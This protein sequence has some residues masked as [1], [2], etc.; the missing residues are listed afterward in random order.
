MK[1][2]WQCERCLAVFDLDAGCEAIE[3]CPT[4]N[5]KSTFTDVTDF[6]KDPPAIDPNLVKK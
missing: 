1:F 2:Y 5:Q 4:C 6:T 3:C